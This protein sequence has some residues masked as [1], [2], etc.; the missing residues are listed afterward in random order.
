MLSLLHYNLCKMRCESGGHSCG[1][2]TPQ[3]VIKHWVVLRN[4][5]EGEAVTFEKSSPR[6]ALKCTVWKRSPACLTPAAVDDNCHGAQW[7]SLHHYFSLKPS[8]CCEAAKIA[9]VHKKRNVWGSFFQNRLSFRGQ[10]VC[11]HCVRVSVYVC[12]RTCDGRGLNRQLFGLTFNNTICH[13][14][15]NFNICACTETQDTFC[16]NSETITSPTLTTRGRSTQKFQTQKTLSSLL[17]DIV[18]HA[19]IL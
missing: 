9:S 14:F 10:L 13:Y 3:K 18:C 5:W 8:S 16:F 7:Q 17:I 15:D 11:W 4:R 6:P 19:M 2:R 1:D 12:V